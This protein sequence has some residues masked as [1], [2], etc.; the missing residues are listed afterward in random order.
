MTH[1]NGALI[2]GAFIV[3]GVL[4]REFVKAYHPAMFPLTGLAAFASYLAFGAA[5]TAAAYYWAP[6][7]LAKV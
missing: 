7:V 3:L 1:N 5:L 6:A 2:V 4:L